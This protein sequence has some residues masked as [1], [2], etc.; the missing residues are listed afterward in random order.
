M[1]LLGLISKYFVMLM[2]IEGF[3][4]G[5]IDSKSLKKSGMKRE[6]Y[7]SK[8]IGISAIIISVILYILQIY[9]A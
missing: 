4:V 7:K 1:R 3:L 9:T 6:A 5:F 8:I 2:V